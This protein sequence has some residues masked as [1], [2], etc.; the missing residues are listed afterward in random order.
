[1]QVRLWEVPLM[2][3]WHKKDVI[4]QFGS[5]ESKII[6]MGKK[7]YWATPVNLQSHWCIKSST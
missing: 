3:L 2:S 5:M 1:M 6:S 7:K 4:H